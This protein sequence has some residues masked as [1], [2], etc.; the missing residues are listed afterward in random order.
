MKHVPRS[1]RVEDYPDVLAY[2]A[3][4]GLCDVDLRILHIEAV[5]GSDDERAALVDAELGWTMGYYAE[6]VRCLVADP[7][8]RQEMPLFLAWLAEVFPGPPTYRHWPSSESFTR[9]DHV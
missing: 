6:N 9:V 3:D 2:L 5:A 8:A 4:R 7:H 1:D